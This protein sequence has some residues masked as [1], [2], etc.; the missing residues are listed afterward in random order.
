MFRW[1]YSFWFLISLHPVVAETYKIAIKNFSSASIASACALFT[2]LLDVNCEKI[3]ID[4][5]T[6][7]V[8]CKYW[9]RRALIEKKYSADQVKNIV[10]KFMIK[11]VLFKAIITSRILQK[12]FWVAKS[13]DVTSKMF[14]F[15]PSVL[16]E[17]K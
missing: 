1:R 3:K 14:S 16:L 6:A 8:I 4:T 12:L 11:A 2:E 9:N 15:Q 17:V 5:R 7:L 13:T 10:S